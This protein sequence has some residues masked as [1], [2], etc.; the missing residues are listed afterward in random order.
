MKKQKGAFRGAAKLQHP[1]V[2]SGK[3]QVSFI[4]VADT[5][6]HFPREKYADTEKLGHLE[7]EKG[8]LDTIRTRSLLLGNHR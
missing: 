7:G 1:D 3:E 5:Q 8:A 2:C 6:L 4:S